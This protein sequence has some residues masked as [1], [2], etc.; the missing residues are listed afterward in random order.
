MFRIRPAEVSD[1]SGIV[2]I[3]RAE[4]PPELLRFTIFGCSGIE[5]HLRD[6]I[7]HQ[8]LGSN[9]WYVLGREDADVLGFTEIRR[10]VDA[11]FINHGYILPA[12]RGPGVGTSL[13]F[14]GVTRART[15]NQSR[16]E[17]DVFHENY[18]VRRGHRALGF[19]EASEQ[20]WLELGP[21][22][23]I[24]GDNEGWYAAGL[25]LADRIHEAYGFSEFDLETRSR[26]YRIGRLGGSL[27][28]ATDA[29]VLA[30]PSASHAL[31]TLDPNRTL[32]CID[33]TDA[34]SDAVRQ[35][36]VVLA[37]N[38]RMAA[39]LNTTLDRLAMFLAF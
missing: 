35:H 25:A 2:D 15:L 17:L 33:K 7:S 24:G 21:D 5:R 4:F 13:L 1:A 27:F 10:D 3:L 12:A 32:L 31:K 9:T 20:L 16:V 18:T 8:D 6:V 23:W 19:R 29:A 38:H 26:S 11:L 30:D 39:D 37:H 14:H 22:D 34:I 36:A 28:R